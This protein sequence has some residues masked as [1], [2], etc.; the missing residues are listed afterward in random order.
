MPRFFVPRANIRDRRALIDGPELAHLR[1]VLRFG[2]G[3]HVTLFDDAGWEHDA[4]IRQLSDETGELEILRSYEAER[5]SKLEI[6]LALGLTKGEKMDWVIEK[7]TELGV[8]SIVPFVSVHAVPKFD[9][10]KIAKRTERWR[11]IAL[12]AAKQ[13]GRSR[14]PAIAALCDYEELI[15]Q[16]TD[17]ALRMLFW[18]REEQRSLRQVQESHPDAKTVLL[19]VGPEVGFSGQEADLARERGFEIVHLG[20]RIL[21]AETAGVTVMSLAQFLWGDLA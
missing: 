18:E 11:K 6:T 14:V 3:D 13:S 2:P 20:R 9:A 19:T 21:R 1:R 12:S 17:A 15:K 4:V 8:Q 5:E 10:V 7:A 16:S